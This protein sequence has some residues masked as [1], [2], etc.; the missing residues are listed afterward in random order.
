M[1]DGKQYFFHPVL[2]ELGVP[3]VIAA[4]QLNGLLL[5]KTDF[6]A[7]NDYM[8]AGAAEAIDNAAEQLSLAEKAKDTTTLTE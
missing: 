4:L 8:L 5:K 6:Y 1:G 3:E 2:A 7:C